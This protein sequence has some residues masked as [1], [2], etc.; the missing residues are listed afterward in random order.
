MPGTK[1]IDLVKAK[2]EEVKKEAKLVGKAIMKEAI[3]RAKAEYKA[4]K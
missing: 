3:K 1:W 2:F 4:S